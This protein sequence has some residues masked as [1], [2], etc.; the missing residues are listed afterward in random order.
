MSKTAILPL[1]SMRMMEL[2]APLACYICEA[3]NAQEVEFCRHC[4]APLALAQQAANQ[5]LRPRMAAALGSNAAGKT[6]YLG[7]LMDM[8]ARMPER[9]QMLARGAFSISLPQTTLRAL[10]RGEFPGPTA[11]EP[12]QWNWVHCQLQQPPRKDTLELILPDMAGDAL[13]SEIEHPN[14]CRIVRLFL[15]R[16]S[17]ALVF[18]DAP[19]LKQG[20]R[21]Q[22][23]FA[24]KVLSYLAELDRDPRKG[25]MSRP[26]AFV[27]TKADACEECWDDPAEFVRQ[28]ATS[29]WQHCQQRLTRHRFFATS[30]AGA[31][32]Q[33]EAA[34]PARAY[35]PLRIEPRGVIE[36]FLWLTEQFP[37]G[38]S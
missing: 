23:F 1:Q 25:W 28:H 17:G 18:I 35:V 16:C 19:R 2:A 21:D 33:R 34:D 37:A 32:G 38:S 9:L 22:E 15:R 10:S 27:L 36:P 29:L 24:L 5:K 4:G 8:L 6:V 3:D 31:C 26:V 12:N 20:R 11:V 7:M 13:L 14:A 30:V